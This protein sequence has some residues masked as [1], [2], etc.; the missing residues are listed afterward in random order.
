MKKN[1]FKWAPSGGMAENV[2]SG[3]QIRIEPSERRTGGCIM[4]E[5]LTAEI[6]N[7]YR[8]LAENLPK[9]VGKIQAREENCGRNF[10]GDA[11][12]RNCRQLIF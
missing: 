12:Y 2:E 10:K 7:E 8:I 3:R 4:P 11:D 9:M 5:L 1:G 6:A